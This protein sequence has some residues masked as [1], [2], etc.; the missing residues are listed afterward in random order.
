MAAD[1]NIL[2]CPRTIWKGTTICMMNALHA[3]FPAADTGGCLTDGAPQPWTTNPHSD[4]GMRLTVSCQAQMHKQCG[5]I[6]LSQLHALIMGG[7]WRV[8]CP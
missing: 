2:G 7:K 1:A 5:Q 4:I 8:D 3:R 6:A